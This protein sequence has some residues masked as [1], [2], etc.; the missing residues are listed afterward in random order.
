MEGF[1]DRPELADLAG[2][3]ARILREAHTAG[4]EVEECYGDLISIAR[5]QSTWRPGQQPSPGASL[6]ELDRLVQV[7]ENLARFLEALAPLIPAGVKVDVAPARTQI[8]MR[9][10]AR[11]LLTESSASPAPGRPGDGQEPGAQEP[12]DLQLF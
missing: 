7:V 10:L 11:A 9:D 3:M 5:G 4:R 12:D 1:E 8:L 6:Q 2:R